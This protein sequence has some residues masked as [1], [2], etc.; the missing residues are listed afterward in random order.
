MAKVQVPQKLNQADFQGVPPWGDALIR[1]MNDIIEQLLNVMSS[2]TF[3]D[4][5]RCETVVGY[6][7]HGVPQNVKLRTLNAAGGGVSLG[8]IGAAVDAFAVQGSSTAG[9]AQVT[10]WFVGAPSTQVKAACII[11][12]DGVSGSDGISGANYAEH[13][14]PTGVVNG[15]NTDF[16]LPNNPVPATSLKVFLNGQRQ[17]LGVDYTLVNQNTI[18]FVAPRIPQNAGGVADVVTAD[19]RY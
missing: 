18:R 12:S 17:T 7:Q 9:Q 2:L 1:T 4:N 19:Y 8:A 14:V 16:V 10:F 15:V 3:S 11:L 13:I 6:F 5:F